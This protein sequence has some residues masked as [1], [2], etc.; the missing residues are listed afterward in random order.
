MNDWVLPFSILYIGLIF[1][2]IIVQSKDSN[3]MK[4]SIIFA[5]HLSGIGCSGLLLIIVISSMLNDGKILIVTNKY[6]ELYFDLIAFG[7]MLSICM[8]GA[9]K[10]WKKKTDHQ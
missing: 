5:S 9:F 1:L 4:K 10:T 3:N 2:Y 6:N 8:Y 7:L